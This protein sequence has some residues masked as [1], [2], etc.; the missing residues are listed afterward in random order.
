MKSA[1][2]F[3]M[4]L[5]WF[6]FPQS[7]SSM[8]MMY[9]DLQIFLCM[10]CTQLINDRMDAKSQHSKH[11]LIFFFSSTVDVLMTLSGGCSLCTGLLLCSRIF[12]SIA[13]KVFEQSYSMYLQIF[14][15]R[16]RF[17]IFRLVLQYMYG[18]ETVSV[19]SW[20]TNCHLSMLIY[21]HIE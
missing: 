10:H 2:W 11:N 9:K 13:S 5:D 18:I 14:A 17:F 19:F 3:S 6:F 21:I 12:V 4:H 8:W 20:K 7:P 1:T 15:K 16:K